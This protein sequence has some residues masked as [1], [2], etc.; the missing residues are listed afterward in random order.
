M[1]PDPDDRR[2]VVA[3]LDLGALRAPYGWTNKMRRAEGW[4]EIGERRSVLLGFWQNL[5]LGLVIYGPF[6]IG[7][8]LGWWAHQQW[9][10]ALYGA[11]IG[12]GIQLCLGLLVAP[13]LAMVRRRED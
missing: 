4:P 10:W 7:A 6:V 3:P 11:G 8:G 1:E 9:A 13:L 12:V 2:R 5:S